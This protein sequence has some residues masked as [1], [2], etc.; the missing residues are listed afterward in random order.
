MHYQKIDI[1]GVYYEGI[2]RTKDYYNCFPEKP[3]GLHILDI[4]CNIGFY[5]LKAI[6]EGAEY[7]F[8]IDNHDIFLNYA[9]EAKD[10]LGYD[11]NI[12]FC[13]ADVLDDSYWEMMN[14]V[15]IRIYGHFDVTLCL[16]LVHHFQTI[17]QVNYLF[18]KLDQ[19]TSQKGKIIFEFL[20]SDS[21]ALW[22]IIPNKLGNRKIH[23]S[24]RFFKERYPDAELFVIDSDVTKGRKLIHVNR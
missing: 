5:C 3:E 14:D 17:D 23:L 22:S 13:Q 21:D 4:G 19:C 24:E 7:C 2:D 18:D 9:N 15:V 16:N 8:G 1:N 11:R 6:S 10:K 12:D 20:D